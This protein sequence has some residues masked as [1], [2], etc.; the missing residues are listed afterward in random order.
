[1]IPLSLQLLN[2]IE[3][4]FLH[5][6]LNFSI[7]FNFICL[8]EIFQLFSFFIVFFQSLHIFLE[9][10]IDIFQF[11]PLLFDEVLM[12]LYLLLVQFYLS[13]S[14]KF[15]YHRMTKYCKIF[16]YGEHKLF[17]S[18]LILNSIQALDSKF[19]ATTFYVSFQVFFQKPYQQCLFFWHFFL[20]FSFSNSFFIDTGTLVLH[21]LELFLLFRQLLC[22]HYL[23]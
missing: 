19:L 12:S 15:L 7:K 4:L 9:H 13:F 10:I 3:L 20:N 8:L 14:F 22:L 21:S 18:L 23:S 5:I 17:F 1:M 11:L 6:L 2:F 16:T